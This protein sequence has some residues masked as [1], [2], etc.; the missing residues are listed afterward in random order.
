MR[1]INLKIKN[2]NSFRAVQEIDF[3]T[4]SAYNVFGIFGNTGSGKSTIIDGITLALY[5]AVSRAKNGKQGIINQHERDMSVE[6]IFSLG[7]HHE[8]R[9]FGVER[10]Y[11]KAKTKGIIKPLTVNNLRSRVVEYIDATLDLNSATVLVEGEKN[12]TDF[13]IQLLG[14]RLEDFR[15]AIIL[16]Q[17]AFAEFLEL[18]PKA[19]REMLERLFSLENYG[20]NLTERLNNKLT[21]ASSIKERLTGELSGLGDASADKVA[22]TKKIWQE[23]QTKAAALKKQFI[24]LQTEYEY[25]KKYYTY[26]KELI[27]AQER[28]NTHE[29]DYPK[30]I[31]AQ[32]QFQRA[33]HAKDLVPLIKEQESLLHEQKKLQTAHAKLQEDKSLAEK[34]IQIQEKKITT[35]RSQQIVQE[36]YW[37]K[38]INLLTNLQVVEKSVVANNAEISKLKKKLF[39]LEKQ[40]TNNNNEISKIDLLLENLQ[41]CKIKN[42]HRLLAAILAEELIDGQACL[43]CGSSKHEKKNHKIELLDREFNFEELL[44][45]LKNF[46]SADST[47]AQTPKNKS[48]VLEDNNHGAQEIATRKKL[49]EENIMVQNQIPELLAQIKLLTKSLEAEQTKL[50]EF[51]KG[52]TIA[53]LLQTINDE[54][55]DLS[56]K[57]RQQEESLLAVQK[58]YQQVITNLAVCDSKLAEN[59]KLL[60]NKETLLLARLQNIGF[61]DKSSCL[62]AFLSADK[63][64]QLEKNIATY[65]DNLLIFEENIHRLSTLIGENF[66]TLAS[67]E[68]TEQEFIVIQTLHEQTVKD[69]HLAE[70]NYQSLAEKQMQWQKTHT[71]LLL[72]TAELENMEE[73]K[74]LLRGNEFVDFL[75]TEQLN[76]VIANASNRLKQLTNNRYALELGE[77]KSFWIRDDHNGG[78][79]RATSSLSGGETFQTSLA[80]ALALS[81]QVQLKG[82]YP[83]EF[84]FLDEGFGSLDQEVLET[85]LSTILDLPNSASLIIGLIS[86][87]EFLQDKMP[88]R[89]IVSGSDGLAVGST[90]HLEIV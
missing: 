4:L 13:I 45:E 7:L 22:S 16:P 71:E 65:K 64:Q 39:Q 25:S 20:K 66:I 52:K 67:W 62:S 9:F 37:S 61:S 15:R 30:Y 11:A 68:K 21:S 10:S 2:L 24:C 82:K 77:D 14:L 17:G 80:L 79:K 36:E 51:T 44:A 38:Q 78:L 50:Q 12:V 6:F 43:V 40:L 72:I 8:K 53:V 32:K 35:L 42:E 81:M 47:P 58:S 1:P 70:A 48:I 86:H 63:L 60:A 83:L 3:A 55:T 41:A 84:F 49:L 85:V 74:K 18:D 59:L 31:A 29:Q 88:R 57:I 89:L 54:K 33:N 19:R 28:K 87:V 27:V 5:G 90:V 75:A 46:L 69:L 56:E 76:L 26:N 34:N 73:L 23:Q